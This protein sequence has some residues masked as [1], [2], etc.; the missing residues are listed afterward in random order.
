MKTSRKSA[1]IKHHLE[2]LVLGWVY[3]PQ[4]SRKRRSEPFAD[5][6]LWNRFGFASHTS[7]PVASSSQPMV[8]YGNGYYTT[9]APSSLPYTQPVGQGSMSTLNPPSYQNFNSPSNGKLLSV[10][11][12]RC[13]CNLVKDTLIYFMYSANRWL[14]KRESCSVFPNIII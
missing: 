9:G 4:P 12:L 14:L 7:L 6:N 8:P 11:S 1:D 2:S 13:T 5:Y 10:L 3:R